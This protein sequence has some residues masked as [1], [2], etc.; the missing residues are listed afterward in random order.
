[1]EPTP[2]RGKR[3]KLGHMARPIKL[4]WTCHQTG[5]CC[6]TKTPLTVTAEERTLLE[7]QG[8][9]ATRPPVFTLHPDEEAQR[10]ALRAR[11]EMIWPEVKFYQLERGPCPFLAGSSCI[12][13]DSR[14]FNCRR[15]MC[16]RVDPT[17][18]SFE[19][20]GEMGCYNLQDRILTSARFEEFAAANQRRAQKWALEH[21]WTKK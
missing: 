6:R 5:D 9:L 4:P 1:M 3:D 16:G 7:A 17:Q 11:G 12:V 14:P 2:D 18:E 20:G 13:Y 8:N 19:E 10:E 15:F 21:G